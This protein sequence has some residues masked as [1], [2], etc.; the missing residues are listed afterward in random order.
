MSTLFVKAAFINHLSTPNEKS[1]NI[2]ALISVPKG[3]KE[4]W[5]MSVLVTDKEIVDRILADAGDVDSYNKLDSEQKLRGSIEIG[6]FEP[7]VFVDKNNKGHLNT[8]G[9]L[10][11][12]T[13]S[14]QVG[15]KK[16]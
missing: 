16:K 6:G 7:S 3:E 2:K 13:V 4:S 8:R 15:G 12:L 1:E 14:E 9:F 5:S 11:K 10:N